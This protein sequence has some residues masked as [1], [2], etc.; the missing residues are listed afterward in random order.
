MFKP[1]W[2]LLLACFPFIAQADFFEGLSAYRN[3]DFTT[4]QQEFS[5]LLPLGN[6]AAV[7]NLAIMA[8]QGKGEPVD[9]VKTAALLTLA[10]ELGEQKAAATAAKLTAS[11]DAS[12]QNAVKKLLTQYQSQLVISPQQ[13]GWLYMLTDPKIDKVP[14]WVKKVRPLFPQKASLNGHVGTVE[15]LA[16]LDKDGSVLFIDSNESLGRD[17]FSQSAKNSFQKWQFEPLEQRLV[18]RMTYGFIYDVHVSVQR[19]ARLHSWKSLQQPGLLEM[20]QQDSAAHQ[21]AFGKILQ[22][23]EESTEVVFH[24]DEKLVATQPLPERMIY[25]VSKQPQRID[26]IINDG[27]VIIQ[28][29]AHNRIETVQSDTAISWLKNTN[30]DVLKDLEMPEAVAAGWYTLTHSRD[31][32]GVESN[33]LWDLQRVP[34]EHYS[35]YWITLAARNGDLEAQR[36]LASRRSDWR[37]YLQQK[38]D[39]KAL[40]WAGMFELQNGNDQQAK[41]LL[42]QAKAAGESQA[43]EL[44]KAVKL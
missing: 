26:P 30:F 11:L 29:N 44:L 16:V 17:L 31:Y 33:Y 37:R 4:A 13:R 14:K 12:Q 15:M 38:N 20:V 8:Y 34:P 3:Q 42:L 35:G 18:Y 32:D 21:F 28:V 10:A 22:R 5:E 9:P 23:L 7:F 2:L 41:A 40:L 43:D 25:Q 6:G 24:P 39:P 19:D 1:S 36:E 27:S